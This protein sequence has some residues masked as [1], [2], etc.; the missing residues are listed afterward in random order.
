MATGVGVSP[1]E[2]ATVEDYKRLE[3][4]C[5]PERKGAV[6]RLIGPLNFNFIWKGRKILT[7]MMTGER[8]N[9]TVVGTKTTCRTEA[10]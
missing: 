8:A 1:V 3:N 7:P 2:P 9:I 5:L 10:P 4:V 6:C